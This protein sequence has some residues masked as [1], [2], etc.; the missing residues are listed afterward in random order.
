MMP[1]GRVIYTRWEYVDRSQVEFHHLWTFNPDGTAVMTYFG[2]THPGNL[3]IDAKPVGQE[4]DVVCIFGPGHGPNEHHGEVRVVS[5]KA[6]PD[7]RGKA[8][9]VSNYEHRPRYGYH[10]YPHRWRDPYPVSQDLFLVVRERELVLMDRRGYYEPVYALPEEV[11][12]SIGGRQPIM[13]HEPRPLVPRERE[14]LVVERTDPSK[15][16]GRMI[17]ADV[18]RGRRM[19]GVERGTIKKLLVLEVMPK[20]VNFSGVQ[21]PMTISYKQWGTYFIYRVLGT[22][23]VEQDGSAHFEVPALRS[24]FFVALDGQNR[25]VKRMHSFTNAMPGEVLSCVGCHEKRSQTGHNQSAATLAALRR[26]ASTIEPV[27]GVPDILDFPRDIQPILDKHCVK[28]HNG[29]KLAARMSL[30]ATPGPWYSHSY[31]NLMLRMEVAHGGCQGNFLPRRTGSS[32]STLM[33]RLEP[34][35]HDVQVSKREKA[36]IRTWIDAGAPWPGTYAALGSGL[37]NMKMP[38]ELVKNRCYSC[39]TR[40]WGAGLRNGGKMPP[41]YFDEFKKRLAFPVYTTGADRLPDSYFDLA[42]PEKSLWLRAPLAKEAGGLGLCTRTK[43][44]EERPI[45]FASTDDEGYAELL[46]TIE[47]TARELGRIKRFHMPEFRPNEHWV[48]EMV[49]YGLLPEDFDPAEDAVDVYEQEEKY[50][51]SFYP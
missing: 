32:Y 16:T 39:H 10:K 3:M 20:P 8:E 31:A 21:F 51:H 4:G 41:S 45:P 11:P 5:P 33:K 17:L 15:K 27:A 7:K 6:G 40:E 2:N 25:S 19:E 47:S 1:D 18:Y 50:W 37:V 34:E 49:R 9:L 36:V 28:C 26:P 48:R 13:L 12:D 23:P 35:H 30:E 46:G 22:V 38:G 42:E 44:G 24:V 29:E 14:P 43:D